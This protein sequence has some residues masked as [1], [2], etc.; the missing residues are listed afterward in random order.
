[1]TDDGFG[2]R[3]HRAFCVM[4]M[5]MELHDR[6][7]VDIE[8]VHTPLYY[9]GFGDNYNRD[10]GP[11]AVYPYAENLRDGYMKRAVLWD[12]RM[13][14]VGKTIT[15]ITYDEWFLVE[16][17]AM[18]LDEIKKDKPTIVLYICKFLHTEYDSGRLDI[19]ILTEYRTRILDRFQFKPY[20]YKK[21]VLAHV[22]RKEC[23]TLRPLSDEFYLE[24]LNAI[25]PHQDKYGEIIVHTQRHGFDPSKYTNF[26][27]VY[28]DESVDYNI[29]VDMA[30]AN[31]LIIGMSC[32]SYAPA[33]LN[34][35]TVIYHFWSYAHRGM[36]QWMNKDQFIKS[37][38]E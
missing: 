29:F 24:I 22:R 19:G 13:N 23:T 20:E 1:V 15:D 9:E 18:L 31:V 36:T 32:F 34:P 2:S 4:A 12:K 27:V 37:L 26:K 11:I 25:A 6:G 5:S 21:V 17:L 33:L 16:S 30:Y 35:N 8:Y 3:M 38:H 7:G 28:D 10:R 14:Y